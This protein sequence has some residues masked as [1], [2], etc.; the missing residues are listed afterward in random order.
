VFQHLTRY[1]DSAVAIS[2]K[3]SD[4]SFQARSGDRTIKSA[5]FNGLRR[6]TARCMCKTFRHPL[7]G[8]TS[9]EGWGVTYEGRSVTRR[10]HSLGDIG[11]GV[12]G[13]R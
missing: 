8:Y 6:T 9:C 3:I 12:L 11:R 10:A 4:S 13:K 5:V 1:A 2:V 7:W